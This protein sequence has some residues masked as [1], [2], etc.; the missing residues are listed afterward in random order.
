MTN[1]TQLRRQL[2]LDTVVKKADLSAALPALAGGA[3]GAGLGYFAGPTDE[4]EEG[5][6]KRN[7]I[8]GGLLG[9][10]AG[11]VLGNSLMGVA[12]NNV[13][14]PIQDALT[15]KPPAAPIIPK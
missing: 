7:A 9:A 14:Q 13:T 8:V 10:G 2:I 11:H 12:K 1:E 3:L 6:G 4:D 5:S 15:G